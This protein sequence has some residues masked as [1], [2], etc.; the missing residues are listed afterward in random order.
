MR[1]LGEVGRVGRK[2]PEGVF[3][4]HFSGR[5]GAAR[6]VVLR[7]ARMV[8]LRRYRGAGARNRRLD[9][10]ARGFADAEEV[11]GSGAERSLPRA[12]VRLD[13][14]ITGAL[15]QRGVS[16]GDD[17]D[18]LGRDPGEDA[19]F[20]TP[21]LVG[22]GAAHRY[23]SRAGAVGHHP[24]VH[25]AVGLSCRYPGGGGGIAERGAGSARGLGGATGRQDI[26]H[27]RVRVGAAGARVASA[28]GAFPLLRTA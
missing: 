8:R 16:R 26:A 21:V 7:A 20:S 27:P 5:G 25:T 14:A 28:D 4:G 13:Q 22:E 24:G 12:G 6:A 18:R 19:L 1:R 15:G 10:A 11:A 9:R 3:G 23:L 2:P 17:S